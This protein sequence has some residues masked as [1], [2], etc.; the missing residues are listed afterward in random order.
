MSCAAPGSDAAEMA[1]VR[2]RAH[3]DA[4]T[5]LNML[6]SANMAHIYASGNRAAVY[7]HE[8]IAFQNT[9]KPHGTTVV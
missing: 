6:L 4:A 1:F 8:Q 5:L 7:L 9:A 2:Q 3:P